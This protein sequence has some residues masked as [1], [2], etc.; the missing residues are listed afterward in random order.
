MIPEIWR[1][2]LRVVLQTS[3]TDEPHEL[4]ESIRVQGGGSAEA[5]A[6]TMHERLRTDTVGQEI[7]RW[8]V[9]LKVCEPQVQVHG[10]PEKRSGGYCCKTSQSVRAAVE[11]YSASASPS[12]VMGIA[13]S[14][15]DMKLMACASRSMCGEESRCLRIFLV[16]L[17]GHVTQEVLAPS[18]GSRDTTQA[19]AI[20]KAYI[21]DL[22]MFFESAPKP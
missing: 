15:V 5:L 16:G 21:A 17:V 1:V 4:I 12:A 14:D 9:R 2:R 7:W 19:D 10:P 18:K 13:G 22:N 11:Q 3:S 6:A 20:Y 8:G